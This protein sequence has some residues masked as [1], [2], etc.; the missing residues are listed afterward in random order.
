VHEGLVV[1]SS[2][3]QR[4]YISG[5]SPDGRES[6][7]GSCRAQTLFSCSP[8][9]RFLFNFSI[10]CFVLSFRPWRWPQPLLRLRQHF[11]SVKA[12]VSQTLF[13]NMVNCPSLFP[14]YL[15]PNLWLVSRYSI[16]RGV[17]LHNV[18][19]SILV[20]FAIFCRMRRIVRISEN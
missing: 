4:R 10:Q 16:S 8:Y 5:W 19:F 1:A 6:I 3:F 14:R 11:D 20:L 12:Q 18:H 17:L 9:A 15:I 13:S 7:A 2:V